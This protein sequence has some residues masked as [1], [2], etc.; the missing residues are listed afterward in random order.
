M[1]NDDYKKA[2]AFPETP[3]L[4]SENALQLALDIESFEID[5]YWKLVMYFWAF[6]P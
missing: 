5:L 2:F 1:T 4:N 3:K 6:S